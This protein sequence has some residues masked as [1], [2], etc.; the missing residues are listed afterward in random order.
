[1]TFCPIKKPFKIKFHSII[2]TSFHKVNVVCLQCSCETI[3]REGENF[4]TAGLSLCA[5]SHCLAYFSPSTGHFLLPLKPG[6]PLCCC[7]TGYPTSCERQERVLILAPDMKAA[8][9]QPPA[10]S[11]L[12][13]RT[14]NSKNV[15]ATY[16]RYN[17]GC[18][19]KKLKQSHYF[20]RDVQTQN[21]SKSLLSASQI[22]AADN[23][24]SEPLWMG[25]PILHVNTGQ[26]A[27]WWQS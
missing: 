26:T 17:S 9:G 1:M 19:L 10:A 7:Q 4:T 12:C 2:C 11:F 24:L 3:E 20:S 16:S 23:N 21:R 15:S 13:P 18:V 6:A 14:S 8:L 25:S 5:S 27:I 22:S